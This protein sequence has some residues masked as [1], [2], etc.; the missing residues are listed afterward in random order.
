MEILEINLIISQLD[1]NKDKTILQYQGR[2]VQYRS[3][4]CIDRSA[5]CKSNLLHAWKECCM[6]LPEPTEN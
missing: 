2:Q 4:T 5:T 1:C 6:Q 3:I